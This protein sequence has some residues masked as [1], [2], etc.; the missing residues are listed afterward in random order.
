MEASKRN[1]R[2]WDQL[3]AKAGHK[4]VVSRNARKRTRAGGKCHT[5]ACACHG[6]KFLFYRSFKII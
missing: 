6:V 4:R 5:E 2:G 3:M 1:R